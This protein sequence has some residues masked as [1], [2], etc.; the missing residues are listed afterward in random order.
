[1]QSPELNVHPPVCDS[2]EYIGSYASDTS[3]RVVITEPDDIAAKVVGGTTVFRAWRL[4]N[5]GTCTWGP[6]YELAF[7]GGRSMGSGGVAFEFTF[8]GEPPRRNALLDPNR[9]VVPQGEP[10]QVAVIELA[11]VAPVTPGIHQ[12]YWRMRNPHGVF[13]GPIVGVTMEVVRDCNFGIY[14]A[15]VINQFRILGVTDPVENITVFEPENP[16]EVTAKLGNTITLDWSIIN[17]ENFD[18]VLQNPVNR[19]ETLSTQQQSGRVSFPV[20]TLGRYV[21]TLYADNGS[22]TVSAVVY[23]NVVPRVGEE[24]VLDIILGASSRLAGSAANAANVQVAANVAASDAVVEWEHPDP[25]ANNFTLRT[26]LIKA[27]TEPQCTSDITQCQ[28]ETWWQWPLM[29]DLCEAIFCSADEGTIIGSAARAVGNDA[30]GSA[31]VAGVTDLCREAPL[32]STEQYSLR[33]QMLA[34]RDGVAANPP[35]S[36]VV[37]VPCPK[38]LRTEIQSSGSLP[39]EIQ[40]GITPPSTPAPNP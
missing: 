6:G 21:I 33:F 23:I 32:D 7:Y 40:P 30:Q 1:M 13:F 24:F 10:N 37:V 25:N 27:G 12:S 28:D 15:P 4:Q 11:L 8:P 22:C 19:L 3:R 14:G 2:A 18:I 20:E 26:Q 29:K 9:L 39:V 17:A 16:I 38:T 36:N 34:E 31:T 5:T 35:R